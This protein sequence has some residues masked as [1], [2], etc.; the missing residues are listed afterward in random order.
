MK[1]IVL[2]GMPAGDRAAVGKAVAGAL[3]LPF[4]DTDAMVEKEEGRPRAQILRENGAP[5]LREAESRCARAAAGRS[6]A[7]ISAGGGVV[8]S[9][10][11]MAALRRSGL[12][13][14][15]DRSGLKPP[16]G[17]EKTPDSGG[18]QQLGV[19]QYR[20]CADVTLTGGTVLELAETIQTVM[21][22][23]GD[24]P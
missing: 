11:D 20:R 4:F 6:G 14:F 15:L 5:Y 24:E 21:E 2:I 3:R 16:A 22:M 1:N 8:L 19:R 18:E 7:V 13:F 9:H 12:V 23:Q 10:G 17:Q